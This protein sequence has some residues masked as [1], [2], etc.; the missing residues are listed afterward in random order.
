ML[1]QSYFVIRKFYK[2]EGLSSLALFYL[3]PLFSKIISYVKHLAKINLVN[4][5]KQKYLFTNS[6]SNCD[7]NIKFFMK[8]RDLIQCYKMLTV[9]NS[10]ELVLI[11]IDQELTVV[12]KTTCDIFSYRSFLQLFRLLRLSR[13]NRNILIKKHTSR[14]IIL[15]LHKLNL[16][17]S[18]IYSVKN[19]WIYSKLPFFAGYVRKTC[20]NSLFCVICPVLPITGF[21]KL[22]FQKDNLWQN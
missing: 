8:Y 6:V 9:K 5:C 2:K 4:I 10:S 22:K 7:S 19:D 15:T 12:K 17:W 11:N 20:L 14:S 13:F 1:K 3:S 18:Y 21:L 16:F